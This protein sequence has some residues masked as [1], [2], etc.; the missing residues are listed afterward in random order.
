MTPEISTWADPLEAAPWRGLDC[1]ATT[2]DPAAYV[3]RADTERAR[4]R[5]ERAVLAGETPVALAGP[6]GLGKTLLL[7]LLAARLG[8]WMAPIH[9]PFPALS[10]E[11]F[12]VL[13]LGLVKQPPSSDPVARLAALAGVMERRGRGLLLLVDDAGSMPVETARGLAK[14]TAECDGSLDVVLAVGPVAVSRQ[15]IDAAGAGSRT[16]SLDEP[17]SL[18]E[19]VSYVRGRLTHGAGSEVASSVDPSSLYEI[20]R[21][22]QGIP[23]RVNFVADTLLKRRIQTAA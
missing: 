1:F 2:A 13:A 20:Y 5:L 15:V 19:T 17:M 6:G 10:L 12:C 16:V 21:E 8:D 14:L 22:S 4:R 18:P 11:E 9:V 3:P 7:R 23:R